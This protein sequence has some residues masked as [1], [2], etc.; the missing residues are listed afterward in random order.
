MRLFALNASIALG[1]RIA[2][3]LGCPLDPH[4]EREFSYGE[5]KVR[6]LVSVWAHDVYVISSLHGDRDL[7]VN[8]KIC[9]LLFFVG[10]LKDAGARSVTAILPYLAYSRKDQKTKPRDPV[11]TRYM[12]TILQ[13]VGVDR[14]ITMDVHNPAALDNSFRCPAVNLETTE[15]FADHFYRTVGNSVDSI[16][17]PDLGGIKA[18]RLFVDTYAQ[19]SGNTLPM[20]V[21]DKRR[22]EGLVSGSGLIGT[23]GDHV[24]I[25]DDMIGSGTTLCRAVQ[26]CLDAGASRVS[27][28]AT[29]GLFQEGAPQLFAQSGIDTITVTDTVAVADLPLL[30]EHRARVTIIETASLFADALREMQAGHSDR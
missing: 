4:E 16:A 13:S 3:Q 19:L 14:V 5:H 15:P 23:V 7:S 1:Q 9:R 12:A 2:E 29:H 10:A 28:A 20:A 11:T 24:L 6:P 22:S 30:D 18:T 25:V 8:D 17:A 27:V 26:A 21:M